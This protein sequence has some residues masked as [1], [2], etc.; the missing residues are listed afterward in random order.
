M[1]CC[2]EL[3]DCVTDNMLSFSFRSVDANLSLDF[4]E[5]AGTTICVGGLSS[6]SLRSASS[7]SLPDSSVMSSFGL[8]SFRVRF[9]PFSRFAIT[10]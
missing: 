5:A 6:S 8:S 3:I 1:A 7:S 10:L 2:I 9:P 4:A